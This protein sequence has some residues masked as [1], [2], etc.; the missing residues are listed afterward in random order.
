MQAFLAV[1]VA[2][3]VALV[4]GLGRVLHVL[5][6]VLWPVA[7]AGVLAAPSGGGKTSLVRALL[8]REPGIR[9]SVSYTTRPPRP[10]E[11]DGVH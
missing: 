9:L 2:L 6:P 1:I 7:V 10:G 8:E 3:I 5:G 11:Q 4:W